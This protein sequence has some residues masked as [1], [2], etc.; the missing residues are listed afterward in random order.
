MEATL[1]INKGRGS[2]THNTRSAKEKN[3][4][5]DDSLI[6]NNIWINDRCKS[7]NDLR[8]MYA[9][10]FGSALSDYNASQIAK[11]HSERQISDYYEKIKKSKQEHL[12]Y[13]FVYQIGELDQIAKG[14]PEEERCI[15]ALKDIAASFE[16]RNPAFKV[17]QSVIHNDEKGIGHLHLVFVPVSSGNKRG[18]ATKNSFVGALKNMGFTGH[19]NFKQWRTAESE[20]CENIMQRHGIDKIMSSNHDNLVHDMDLYKK[21]KADEEELARITPNKPVL[22][23]FSDKVTLR[24][25]EFEILLKQAKKG[26][27]WDAVQSQAETDSKLFCKQKKKAIEEIKTARDD[28]MAYQEHLQEKEKRLNERSDQLDYREANLRDAE[29]L[30]ELAEDGKAFRTFTY[31]LAEI[32]FHHPQFYESYIAPMVDAVTDF[33]PEDNSLVRFMIRFRDSCQ[34]I[35]D[36]HNRQIK[37][38]N[39]QI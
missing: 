4:T 37:S 16:E 2:L 6:G 39:R 25:S 5:W 29:K 38:K 18:L 10:E 19:D 24:S 35:F 7:S 17:A 26:V 14:S 8:K 34:E 20:A 9:E 33:F 28:L 3:Q 30:E 12:T 1:T 22:G 13:S 23:H 11:G 21:M 31:H 36:D 15:A 27:K 32:A